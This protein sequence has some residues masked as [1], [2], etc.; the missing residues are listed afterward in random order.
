MQ[1]RLHVVSKWAERIVILNAEH[2]AIELATV[3]LQADEIRARLDALSHC[4]MPYAQGQV[5]I[6]A[7]L[8]TAIN[9]TSAPR[10]DNPPAELKQAWLD[11]HASLMD[12]ADA[13][14]C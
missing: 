6:T 8:L 5:P 13:S 7:T 14:V 4:A 12:N 2:L 10:T 1:A 9:S 3:Q 11:Q